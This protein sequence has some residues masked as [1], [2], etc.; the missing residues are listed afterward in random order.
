MTLIYIRTPYFYEEIKI[1]LPPN[2][3]E[4]HH[5]LFTYYH[6]SFKSESSG[7]IESSPVG[8][9]VSFYYFGL[10]LCL[11]KQLISILSLIWMGSLGVRFEVLPLSKTP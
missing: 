3:G 4:N 1:K 5:L 2:L 6:V 10:L 8:Y 9:T 11:L 7:P